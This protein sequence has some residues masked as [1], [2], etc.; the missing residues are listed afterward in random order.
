MKFADR[1]EFDG[2]TVTIGGVEPLGY[3]VVMD[4]DSI[5]SLEASFQIAIIKTNLINYCIAGDH[6]ETL[7]CITY[8]HDRFETH[9]NWKLFL[10]KQL[11][12]VPA[13]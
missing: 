5:V 9:K 3:D 11:N 2:E 1:L 4:I 12:Y 10:K 8:A 13:E 6:R 7:R